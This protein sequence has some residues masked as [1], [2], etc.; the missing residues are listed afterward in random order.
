MW[1]AVSMTWAEA[2]SQSRNVSS[3][4]TFWLSLLGH[5][6]LGPT[7]ALGLG[8]LLVPNPHRSHTGFS[9]WVLQPQL[10]PLPHSLRLD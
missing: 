5:W 4:Y 1:Q 2:H 6:G 3:L 10:L 9:E 7:L 8:S